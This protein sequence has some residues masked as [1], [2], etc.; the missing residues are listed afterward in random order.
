M[1]KALK[2][3]DIIREI[4]FSFL[5]PKKYRVF[6]FGSRASGKHSKY[7]DYD[8]GIVSE[9]ALLSETKVLI[10]E[11]MEESDLPF[12]VDIVDFSLVSDDF[13]KIALSSVVELKP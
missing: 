11:A 13:R 5:D 10:E 3:E 1:A 7:S 8:V 6:I 9:K 12:K 2:S 4:M